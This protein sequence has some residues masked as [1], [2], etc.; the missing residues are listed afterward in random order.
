[1]SYQR[2]F[3]PVP[4]RRLGRSLG[5][6]NIPPKICS[7]A[8][9]YCQLG[10]ALGMTDQRQEFFDPQEL[11]QEVS[12]KVKTLTTNQKKVD[13]LTVVPDGEPT[14]DL[15]LGKL[16]DL[17]KPLGIK[18]AVISN[19]SLIHLPSVREDLTHADWVSLKVD[20]LLPEIWKAVNRPHGKVHLNQIKEGI[21]QFTEEYQGTLVTETMLV[22]NVNDGEENISKI[23]NFLERINPATAYLGIPTRPPA[24]DYV[25]PPSEEQLN[26]AFQILLESGLHAEYLIGYEGNEFSSTGDLETDLLS[27]TSV[28]PM[29]E[30]AVAATLSEAGEDF[31][32]IERLIE[33]QKL[34]VST[35]QGKR[36]YLRK[37]SRK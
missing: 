1:M 18:L 33:E 2:V 30:D 11:A 5:I 24:E 13:Y 21:Q 32:V 3:G 37:F 8:C 12:E 28:H 7:Y 23:A 19:A 15:N 17:L 27:I 26:R 16:L 22:R 36:Y 6:N 31:S 14:L 25:S 35:Y 9:I 20:S 10:N 34:A 29:R 4:S